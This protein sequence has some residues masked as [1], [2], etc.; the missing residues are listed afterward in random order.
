MVRVTLVRPDYETHIVTPPLGLG[1]LSS[2][3]SRH[4]VE[5][6]IIDGL[7]DGLSNTEVCQR[8]LNGRSDAI[9]L[10]CLTA[11][12]SQ[13]V[14]LARL[15]K[16]QNKTVI[17]GGVHPTFLPK[18]T[19]EETRCDYVVLGEG[20]RPL[21][22]LAQNGFRNQ[23]FRGVYSRQD[24]AGVE[25]FTKAKPVA[26]LDD[27]P[28][29]DWEQLDPRKYP[30]APH[31]AIVKRF[32]IGVVMTSRGC[33]FGCTF[34][35]SPRFYDRKVR[36]RSPENVVEEIEYLVSRFGVREIHFEDDNLTLN[37]AYVEK[38]CHLILERAIKVTWA[39]PNGIR[40]DSVDEPLVRLMR[41]SGCYYFAYGIESVN[42]RILKEIKK[43]EDIG[44][45]RQAIDCASRGGISC[46]GFFIFGLPGE[47]PETIEETIRFASESS[48]SRAQF[49]I[50]DILPGSELW[51]T[52]KG[53]FRPNW[54]KMSYKE[55]E[56]IPDG[57]TREALMKAQSRAF[58]QFYL[59]S[60][61][62]L[63][64][65]ALS[66]RPR[67]IHY[68]LHRLRD[69]RIL[70]FNRPGADDSRRPLP[71]ARQFVAG[72]ASDDPAGPGMG[73]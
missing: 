2:Y 62:R 10:T 1:Y 11:F 56:W 7:R 53:H 55:P 46:Q 15:L 48:L 33:P 70:S 22:Q 12:Y 66:V 50:L 13:V 51:D 73:R 64:R 28:F 59:K 21:L 29:P 26:D 25:Q 61:T 68:L 44:T 19:L 58:R 38:L 27:L 65:L 37:H 35:A 5:V 39:C 4:G 49:L 9:G 36:F 41:E 34:C 31:G 69:Y 6:E 20:E 43:Q 32:P 60:P 30:P 23:N 47:T 16:S 40:A 57:L 63:L 3:L 67:Q 8:I 18:E 42:S 54:S 71:H 24:L 14:D 45:I 17:I 52:L 72:Q